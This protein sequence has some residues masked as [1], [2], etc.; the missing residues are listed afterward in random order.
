MAT[1][2]LKIAAAGAKVFNAAGGTKGL[3][4]MGLKHCSH[5]KGV[6]GPCL[7]AF[8]CPLPGNNLRKSQCFPVH[9]GTSCDSCGTANFQG[10]RFKCQDC[11][12]FDLCQSCYQGGGH[13]RNHPFFHIAA[14]GRLP[15]LMEPRSASS[16]APPVPPRE[17]NHQQSSSVP[18]SASAVIQHT[19]VSCD[20]CGDIP[21][22]SNRFKC[23]EC[24]NF[25]LC[26][27]CYSKSTHDRSHAFALIAKEGATPILLAS[28]ASSSTE[29]TINV[30]TVV[31]LK[32]LVNSSR[33]NGDRGTIKQYIPST[34]RKSTRLNSSHVD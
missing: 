24:A 5:C 31:S 4:A 11:S 6:Q 34:D 2:G 19:G 33:F 3:A 18:S 12:D 28:P 29:P 9:T 25:D 22:P 16:A 30:G 32:D 7:C 10:S 14:V 1:A 26:Q 8:G 20:S 15:V 21:I 23:Q 27:K 13:D 17:Y